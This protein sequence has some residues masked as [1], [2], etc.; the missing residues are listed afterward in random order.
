LHCLFA[1]YKI[2]FFLNL[3]GLAEISS[4]TAKLLSVKY[5]CAISGIMNI[6]KKRP[7]NDKDSGDELV[8][9]PVSKEAIN[10]IRK[11]KPTIKVFEEDKKD[12]E[13]ELHS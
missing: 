2:E 6:F 4:Q 5:L 8:K 10:Q 11:Q 12:E 13:D 9:S 3:Q 1:Y 7:Q